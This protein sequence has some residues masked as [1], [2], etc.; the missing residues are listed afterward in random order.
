MSTGASTADNP[1]TGGL[2]SCAS[3]PPAARPPLA[4]LPAGV[5]GVAYRRPAVFKHHYPPLTTLSFGSLVQKK[6]TLLTKSAAFDQE[7]PA[8]CIFRKCKNKNNSTP[9]SSHSVESE[10]P[11][12]ASF[13]HAAQRKE[14]TRGRASWVP[15]A[16][17]Y[18]LRIGTG[19]NDTE[20]PGLAC[21][22]HQT[23]IS[24]Q[25]EPMLRRY[26]TEVAELRRLL[27]AHV[28]EPDRS[29]QQAAAVEDGKVVVQDVMTME[30]LSRSLV[31]AKEKIA[32]RLYSSRAARPEREKGELEQAERERWEREE[33]Q[34]ALMAHAE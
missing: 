5:Q 2:V 32:E 21:T 22:P 24:L 6:S 13:I 33:D 11:S 20:L 16:W 18:R 25:W 28:K 23:G 31:R 4:C 34:R 1:A 8:I 27:D 29:L 10:E 17:S 3:T 12:I 26:F 30:L 9:P 7:D 15:E 19:V 14:P